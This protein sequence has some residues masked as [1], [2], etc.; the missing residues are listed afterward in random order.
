MATYQAMGIDARA[1]ALQAD[2]DAALPSLK[3]DGSAPWNQLVFADRVSPPSDPRSVGFLYMDDAPGP[4][5]AN[6]QGGLAAFIMG[7]GGD[8]FVGNGAQDYLAYSVT[9]ELGHTLGAVQ[10]GAPHSTGYGHC[11]DGFAIM[12]YD[13]GGPNAAQYTT[14]ACAAPLGSYGGSY[15]GV[16]FDCGSND[17]LSAAPPLG[18]WLATHWN[19]FDSPFMCDTDSCTG[20][21]V[22]PVAQLR[23]SATRVPA[24]TTVTL[25]ASGSHDDDGIV[26][27]HRFDLD[28]DGTF[29]TDRGVY[30]TA[31]LRRDAA[32]T[33]T[34]GVEVTDNDGLSSRATLTIVFD[35]R[36]PVAR[37]SGPSSATVGTPVTLDASASSDPDAGDAI[38]Y[39]WR[40]D[41]GATLGAGPTASYTP[42][43]AGTRVVTVTVRDRAGATS[44]ASWSIAV[45][46]ARDAGTPLP[47]PAPVPLPAN[48]GGGTTS[49]PGADSAR[50]ATTSPAPGASTARSRAGVVR[51]RRVRALAH[52]RVE[53]RLACP[54]L[55]RTC[56]SRI[57][58]TVRG[59]R[60]RVT[61][62]LP[63][64]RSRTVR[65]HPRRAHRGRRATVRVRAGSRRVA[66]R[67]LELR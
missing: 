5:N 52:G 2:L 36:A 56:R 44:S 43:S 12:C 49:G 55:R 9:H 20:S 35:D 62:K 21:T 66:T 7:S 30:A 19:T 16:T 24:G 58:V 25:D 14:S 47:A 53:V 41:A 28:G 15:A 48:P 23:A 8:S 50:T 26:A 65:V 31:T 32:A 46:G 61:L 29:E 4:Q 13:D 40:D 51:V 37:V 27:S 67:R 59:A 42:A 34:V 3:L 64:G 10:D 22:A 57:D 18:S 6:A 11:T 39:A 45:A 17:Y 63:A 54:Q 1:D 38:T 60:T 33:V